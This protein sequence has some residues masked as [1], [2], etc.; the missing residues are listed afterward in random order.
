MAYDFTDESNRDLTCASHSAA[1]DLTGD[2]MVVRRRHGKR[3]RN[4]AL[5]GI[6]QA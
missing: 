6:G 3:R 1:T 4:P 2:A 5:C